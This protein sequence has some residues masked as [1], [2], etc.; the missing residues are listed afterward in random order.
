MESARTP[1]QDAARSEIS[2]MVE[3]AIDEL[4]ET[5]RLVFLM[6]MVEQ[7]SIEDTAAALCIDPGTVKTRLHR[8]TER[9]RRSLGAELASVIEG[10]FPFAGGRC[11]RLVAAVLARLPPRISRLEES[12][13][14]DQC[15]L[16]D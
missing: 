11:Q 3:R 9:L 10:A 16:K 12:Q 6:R 7:M 15:V 4:P 13:G 8:A 2:R 14:E 1:E 5:F